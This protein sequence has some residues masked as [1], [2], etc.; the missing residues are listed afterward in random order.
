MS[1]LLQFERYSSQKIILIKPV[2]HVILNYMRWVP[3]DKK[4]RYAIILAICVI[5]ISFIIGTYFI[6]NKEPEKPEAASPESITQ[7]ITEFTAYYPEVNDLPG[8]YTIENSSVKL[9]EETFLF[10]VTIPGGA[11]INI[12][13]QALPEEFQKTQQFLGDDKIDT[14]I[15]SATITYVEGRTSA[16]LISKD[17]KTLVIANSNEAVDKSNIRAVLNSLQQQ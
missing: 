8:G 2:Y 10:T 11:K 17:R 9:E 6:T 15:G 14:S 12:S 13:E 1:K 5:I 3:S 16:F 7:N 4:I